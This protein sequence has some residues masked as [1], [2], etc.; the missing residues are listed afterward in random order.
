MMG[1]IAKLV[2]TYGSTLKSLY[3][4][5]RISKAPWAPLTTAFRVPCCGF[6]PQVLRNPSVVE[7]DS[8]TRI[9]AL[10]PG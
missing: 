9:V 10:L 2:L 6:L 1:R 4:N 5:R 3:S 7:A 8:G